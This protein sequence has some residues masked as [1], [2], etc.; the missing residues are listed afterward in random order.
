MNATR[1]LRRV[2]LLLLALFLFAVAIRIY[3]RKYYIWLP[4]Y[5]RMSLRAP[6]EARRP[7]HVF[8]LV[9][10]HFE[11]GKQRR[12]LDRWE[13]DYPVLARR[14]RDSD[15]RPP[16]HTWFYPGE[17][18]IDTNLEALQ[19]LVAGGY[20][21]V[22][23]H[24]H[25]GN[26]DLSSA[27]RKFSDAVAWF[28]RFGFL[29][30]VDGRTAFAFVHGNSTLD[31]SGSPAR[32]GVN[33]ELTLLRELGCFAD[34]TFPALWRDTQPSW[35]NQIAMARD[36]GNPKS[37]DR[38]YPLRVGQYVDGDLLLFQ[39]P[40]QIYPAWDLRRLFW[41]V[42]D[43]DIHPT[44]PVDERRVDLWLR[45]N[46]HVAGRPDWVFIKVHGH[47]ASSDADA[48][49]FLGSNF[50]RALSHL[51]RRYNDG[52]SYV[53]HYVTAREAY[54]LVRAAEAGM[55]GKPSK[56]YDYIVKPYVANPKGGA[57]LR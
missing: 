55:T 43:G 10:D 7:V 14:H 27:R 22:E 41:R 9:V 20:G 18:P 33:R 42:E 30:T 12:I 17:Q 2:S 51:E 5:I 45:A 23:L 48:G 37:Y 24:Y 50:D 32:C 46:I 13:R 21:D 8:F 35:V 4:D 31:N 49:E 47:G 16:Q 25:H 15:G 26:D 29:K 6:V 44:V 34:F 57:A 52:N 3:V 38:S 19:W 40:L 36:D 1:L 54:N 53:L 28:Q 39:G 56:Y 11:P